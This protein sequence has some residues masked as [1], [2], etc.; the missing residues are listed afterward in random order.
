VG[1][2]S[3]SPLELSPAVYPRARYLPSR[4]LFFYRQNTLADA[5]DARPSLG[6]RVDIALSAT[7]ASYPETLEGFGDSRQ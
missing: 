3:G 2:R 5:I 1:G 6:Y 4:L 7:E